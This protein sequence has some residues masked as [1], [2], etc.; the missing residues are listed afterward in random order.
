MGGMQAETRVSYVYLC[1]IYS[2]VYLNFMEHGSKKT[3]ILITY[4]VSII[5]RIIQYILTN[6]IFPQR[7]QKDVS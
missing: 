4:L 2:F 5:M 3:K 7:F 6:V 1:F